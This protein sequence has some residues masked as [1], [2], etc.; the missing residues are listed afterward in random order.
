VPMPSIDFIN[1][2]RE[3]E[4]VFRVNFQ[5]YEAA[6]RLGMDAR[7][8][9]CID[10]STSD[11]RS[12]GDESI[13]GW[14]FPIASLEHGLNRFWGFGSRLGAR[15]RDWAL[16]G[17]P[18]FLPLAHRPIARRKL[19]RVH[20]IRHLTEHS[21]SR[22]SGWMYRYSIPRLK[23]ADR[24]VVCTQHLKELI[25]ARFGLADRTFI[26][27]PIRE[28]DRSSAS[29]HR[30]QSVARLKA[31]R[32][33]TVLYV[34]TDRPYKNLQL[35]ARLAKHLEGDQDPRFRFVLVS[36]LGNRTQSELRA[37]S[38]T[39]LT[40]V[41]IAPDMGEVYRSAD[42]LAFPSVHEGFGIPLLEA[43]SYGMPVVAHDLEPMREVI[44]G[45]G[46]LLPVGDE[47]RWIEVL[48]RLGDP[49]NYREASLRADDR[50]ETY[51]PARVYPLLPPLFA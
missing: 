30:E 51:S 45:G 13:R 2:A 31:N 21:D 26:V 1:G 39:N 35:F 47:A 36:R 44:G 5:L 18:T 3:I 29:G 28:T 9:E 24:L 4:G 6:R 12:T 10:P 34:A 48:R 43:M 32:R 27:P 7:W 42:V 38:A 49:A 17:D 46:V 40:I 33:L 25:G 23:R 22:T 41:G 37:L 19:V 8:V 50:A 15:D 20:D 16:L 11:H 14:S